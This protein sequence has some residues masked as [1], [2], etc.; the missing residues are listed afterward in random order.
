MTATALPRTF[1]GWKSIR[2]DAH[3]R[4]ARDLRWSLSATARRAHPAQV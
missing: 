2:L 1:P 4:A 3:P